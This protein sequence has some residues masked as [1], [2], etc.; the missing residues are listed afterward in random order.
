MARVEPERRLASHRDSSLF[1]RGN[2]IEPS[3]EKKAAGRIHER[4]GRSRENMGHFTIDPDLGRE[5]LG[6]KIAG[7]IEKA[8][9]K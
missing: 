1:K 9:E 8:V 6:Q 2:K 4:K 5:G 3:S 7:Q